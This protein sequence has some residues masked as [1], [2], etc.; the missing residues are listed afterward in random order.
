MHRRLLQLL[1]RSPAD[2]IESARALPTGNDD[3]RLLRA[4]IL[5]DAGQLTGDREAVDE[6][7]EIYTEL[8]QAYPD[9]YLL[10]Y[11]LANALTASAQLDGPLDDK[12]WYLRT[13][14]IRRRS[15]SLNWKAAIGFEQDD[16]RQASQALTNLANALDTA[17]RWIEAFDNY[18]H[19]MLLFPENGVASG[20]AARVLF[21]V[22]SRTAFGHEN[23]MQD[24]ALRLAH[25]CKENMDVV[26][27]IAGDRAAESFQRLPSTPNPLEPIGGDRA[28]SEYEEFVAKHRLFL[29]PIMEGRGH[30]SQ[31]WDDA[32]ILSVI[33]PIEEVSQVPPVFA[34]FNVLKADYLVA[35]D[36][37]FQAF[38]KRPLESGLYMDTLDYA[39]YGQTPA[40]LVLAQRAALDLLD[41]VAVAINEFFRLGHNPRQVDFR[42][43][44]SDKKNENVWGPRLR[45]LIDRQNPALIALSEIAADIAVAATG[46]EA[47]ILQEERKA[48][49]AGTHRF[50]VLHDMGLGH[51]IPSAAIQRYDLHEYEKLTLR[52]T[53]LARAALLHFLEAIFYETQATIRDGVQVAPITVRT[54]H[55]IRGEDS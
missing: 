38:A 2:A 12:A 33:E 9:D 24:V 4:A 18:M 35:R 45:E 29:A 55:Y 3:L 20:N 13:S 50:T 7:V 8:L 46:S 54:H 47:G 31:R 23:H 22:S 40:R 51:S 1:D 32:H 48:R 30:A 49:H 53:R 16:R 25:H 41:K 52:T 19:A 36:L 42:S 21:R 27:V 37:L 39:L 11:N 44:W 15:R 17:H 34:M 10:S 28:V 26:R 43:I 6:A 5:C 14:D